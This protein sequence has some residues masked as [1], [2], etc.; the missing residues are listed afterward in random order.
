MIDSEARRQIRTAVD[1]FTAKRITAFA[2]DDRLNAIQTE[3]A[4][5]ISVTRMIWCTY[6]DLKDHN[7]EHWNKPTWDFVQRLL[8]LLESGGELIT[9]RSGWIWRASQSVALGGLAVVV[10]LF[11]STHPSWFIPLLVGGGISQGIAWWRDRSEGLEHR[12]RGGDHEFPFA[13][14]QEIRLALRRLP[15]W[16][17]QRRSGMA[18]ARLRPVW[19]DVVLALPYRVLWCLVSPLTL[20]TQALPRRVTSERVVLPAEQ[21]AAA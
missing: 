11:W 12:R 4:T 10:G 8:L 21:G 16:R 3:D 14:A 2:L 15:G 9:E 13:S 1:D 18:T 19:M 20:M 5:A 6:D 7:V 17:K